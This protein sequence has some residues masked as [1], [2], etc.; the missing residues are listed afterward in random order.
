MT[1][2][3]PNTF[4]YSYSYSSVGVYNHRPDQPNINIYTTT[5]YVAMLSSAVFWCPGAVVL[6]INRRH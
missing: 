3:L 2:S 5:H 4:M 1:L 6:A